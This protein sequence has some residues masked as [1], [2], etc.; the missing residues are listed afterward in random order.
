MCC[1][2]VKFIVSLSPAGHYNFVILTSAVCG[3]PYQLVTTP[4]VQSCQFGSFDLST[5]TGQDLLWYGNGYWWAIRPCG[6]VQSTGFCAGQF[7]QGLNT[8]SLWNG[9]ALANYASTGTDNVPLW[10]YTTYNNSYGIAQIIQ[11]GTSCGG[12]VGARQG[13][14]LF[15]CNPSASTP[16]IAT[17]SE[18]VICQQTAPHI[19]C[20][21]SH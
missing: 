20:D 1:I 14:I 12:N 3:T 19:A 5:L 8:V 9:T 7:C 17:V 11:D 6:T 16:Y 10:A 4:V 21:P 18:T 15:V 13:T 2:C